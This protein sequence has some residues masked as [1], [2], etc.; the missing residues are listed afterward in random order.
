ML[1]KDPSIQAD[2]DAIGI[3][4]PSTGRPTAL[5]ATEYL[6]LSKRTRLVFE[7]DAVTAWR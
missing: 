3:A 6:L 7:T 1:R 5:P 4:W 2:H